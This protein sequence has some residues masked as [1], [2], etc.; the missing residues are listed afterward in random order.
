MGD[1]KKSHSDKTSGYHRYFHCPS[2]ISEAENDPTRFCSPE[3]CPE[4]IPT[5]RFSGPTRIL[6]IKEHEELKEC[7]HEVN[8]LLLAFADERDSHLLESF[9]LKV[10]SMRGHFVTVHVLCGK[11]EIPIEGEL[12]DAGK[13]FLIIDHLHQNFFVPYECICNINHSEMNEHM[14]GRHGGELANLNDCCRRELMLNFGEVVAANPFLINLFFGMRLHKFLCAF[15]KSDI[16]VV[17]KD[18]GEKK[19]CL[20]TVEEANLTLEINESKETISFEEICFIK[21]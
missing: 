11:A 8:Q 7:I 4:E 19:G 5:K 3:E 17:T 21:D 14:T 18:K 15:L 16:C 9:R 6:P 10:K 2:C 13:D 1:I 12:S 20:L